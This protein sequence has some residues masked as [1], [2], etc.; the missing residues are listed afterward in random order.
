MWSQC[1]TFHRPS[2]FPSWGV[3]VKS[4]MFEHCICSQSSCLLQPRLHAEHWVKS[5]C[6]DLFHCRQHVEQWVKSV[7][8]SSVTTGPVT[9]NMSSD[10]WSNSFCSLWPTR[11]RLQQVTQLSV[12]KYTRTVWT[13]HLLHQPLIMEAE[14]VSDTSDCPHWHSWHGLRKLYIANSC[15][16]VQLVSTF[17]LAVLWWVQKYCFSL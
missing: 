14:I 9:S 10:D 13:Q 16:F 3:A 2:L 17:Q 8:Q 4:V 1:L 11:S 6:D 7:D 12:Y 5:D 15:L